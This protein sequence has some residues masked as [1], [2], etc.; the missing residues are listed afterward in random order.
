MHLPIG[1]IN[2]QFIGGKTFRETISQLSQLQELNLISINENFGVIASN[3][4]KLKKVFLD[5]C[6][7]LTE[8]GGSS[9]FVS[10]LAAKNPEL[11]EL[12]LIGCLEQHR[13]GSLNSELGIDDHSIQIIA[14]CCP[15]LKRLDLGSNSSL[16][17]ITD[18]SMVMLAAK[19]SKLE[20]ISLPNAK[21][22]TDE[23]LNAIAKYCPSIKTLMVP[24]CTL[25]Q[26][27]IENCVKSLKKLKT[28]HISITGLQHSFLNK[29]LLDNPTLVIAWQD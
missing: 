29:I 20:F 24:G 26:G 15:D 21:Q 13:P 27:G 28:I 25:T 19:C 11:E 8:G 18:K 16:P 6:G 14:E 12:T 17:H 10:S 4:T 5:T 23:T 9:F 22:I 1:I 3:L 7:F 2:Y